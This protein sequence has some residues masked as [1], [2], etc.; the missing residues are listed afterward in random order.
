MIGVLRFLHYTDEL[1]ITRFYSIFSVA[2]ANEQLVV[3]PI[4]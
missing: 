1:L 2:N 3:Y 4:L